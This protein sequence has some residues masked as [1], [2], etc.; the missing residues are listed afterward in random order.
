MHL[1]SVTLSVEKA[2]TIA[3]PSSSGIRG[4]RDLPLR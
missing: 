1:Y 3:G 2:I 4:R